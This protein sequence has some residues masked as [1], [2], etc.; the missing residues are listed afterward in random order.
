MPASVTTSSK[1]LAD[2]L[3]H[4]QRPYGDADWK[5]NVN[6]EIDEYWRDAEHNS[7]T[8]SAIPV[9]GWAWAIGWESGRKIAQTSGCQSFNKQ[10]KALPWRRKYSGY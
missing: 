8:I 7:N 1:R 5:Q 4:Y 10:K 6:N 2:G 3:T 9:V